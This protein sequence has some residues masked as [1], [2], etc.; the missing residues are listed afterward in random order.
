M[1]FAIS[2]NF[3]KQEITDSSIGLLNNRQNLTQNRSDRIFVKVLYV[4]DQ[5]PHFE[6]SIVPT[7]MNLCNNIKA[8]ISEDYSYRMTILN[9]ITTMTK[10][11]PNEGITKRRLWKYHTGYIWRTREQWTKISSNYSAKGN[12][13]K[14]SFSKA[15]KTR[16]WL[17]K[18]SIPL[19]SAET[20]DGVDG[21]ANARWK[22][23]I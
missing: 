1:N 14:R 23:T 5:R 7:T 19:S 12:T 10:R 2:K 11:S 20:N 17:F 22:H 18:V 6:T 9:S 16:L 4:G 8:D 13:T 15:S 21:Y 3:D